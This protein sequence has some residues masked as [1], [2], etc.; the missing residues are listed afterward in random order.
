L[1]SAAS[2]RAGTVADAE[3]ADGDLAHRERALRGV[4]A[5]LAD[6]YL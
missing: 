1:Q 6:R 3:R 5:R 2:Y 4:L